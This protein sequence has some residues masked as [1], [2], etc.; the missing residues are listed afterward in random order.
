M[1]TCKECKHFERKK[2]V[3]GFGL[4]SGKTTEYGNCHLNPPTTTVQFGRSESH[5]RI[6]HENDWCSFFV[7][8]EAKK[9]EPESE[10]DKTS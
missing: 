6:V 3:V 8:Q 10:D 2:A 7:E 4:S 5:Y 1:S 9:E